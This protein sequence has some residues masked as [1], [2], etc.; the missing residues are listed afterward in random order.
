M[1]V[2][3]PRPISRAVY[4]CD[5]RFHTEFLEEMTA[6]E[7]IFGY[8][9][10]DGQDCLISMIQGNEKKKVSSHASLAKSR[11]R[12]GGSSSGRFQRGRTEAE[13]AFV[14]K[15][16]EGMTAAFL[17]E[18]GTPNVSGIV[19]AGKANVKS[20][21]MSCEQLDKRIRSIVCAVLD[22]QHSGA[23]G[24]A[25]AV[26]KSEN[27]RSGKLHTNV[28]ESLAEF[29]DMINNN[30]DLCC[31]GVDDITAALKAKAIKILFMDPKRLEKL[32]VPQTE[33]LETDTATAATTA[34]NKTEKAKNL[35]DWIHINFANSNI[36]FRLISDESHAGALF[37]RVYGGI[38][39]ILRWKYRQDWE[40]LEDLAF[41]AD[42]FTDNQDQDEQ[43][44]QNGSSS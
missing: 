42:E 2:H 15:I 43:H 13:H 10:C 7:P 21:V 28:A 29:D 44:E 40:L 39:A 27:Q 18:D 11:S 33:D 8:V 20:L 5:R 25:E 34:D 14:K 32:P 19:I 1:T 22:I 24:L 17:N 9:I 36:D 6:D 26:E 38:G 23:E 16:C 31:F 3:P 35:F 37:S 12:R 41:A 4:L 30:P